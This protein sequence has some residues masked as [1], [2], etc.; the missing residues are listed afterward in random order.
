MREDEYDALI[1]DPTGFLYDV[2]L[3]RVSTEVAK[4]GDPS[5]RRNNLSFVKIHRY[6]LHGCRE[7]RRGAINNPDGLD[8]C[9]NITT[10]IFS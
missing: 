1:D 8:S 2:W 6:I 10:F 5:T 7:Y 9:G 4:I 3:P